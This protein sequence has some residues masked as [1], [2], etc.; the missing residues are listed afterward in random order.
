MSSL[1]NCSLK[2]IILR[3]KLCKKKKK[4][5]S[6]HSASKKLI[7]VQV[8]LRIEVVTLCSLWK[9]KIAGV[10]SRVPF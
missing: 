9:L 4:T 5:K 8:F 7:S 1:K 3:D 6:S 2:N 10:A